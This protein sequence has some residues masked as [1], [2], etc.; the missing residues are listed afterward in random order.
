MRHHRFMHLFG[1]PQ[2]DA[3]GASG[4]AQV[5]ELAGFAVNPMAASVTPAQAQIYQAAFTLAQQQH[6]KDEEWPMADCWN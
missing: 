1:K 6:G 4:F 2:I 3:V 5:T